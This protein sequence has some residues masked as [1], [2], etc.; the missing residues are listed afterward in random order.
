[1]EGVILMFEN[2]WYESLDGR[3]ER[4]DTQKELEQ[5]DRILL[6]KV[7]LGL[8]FFEVLD[9]GNEPVQSIWQWLT[10][11]SIPD[12]RRQ[13]FT[14]A[15]QQA[16]ANAPVLLRFGRFDWI[17]A[18]KAY[19]AFPAKWRMY[20]IPD[21]MASVMR[22][23]NGPDVVTDRVQKYDEFL[24]RS[25][26]PYRRRYMPEISAGN[27]YFRT[28]RRRPRTIVG[29]LNETLIQAAM[30]RSIPQFSEQIQP[31]PPIKLTFA[32][33]L[34]IAQVLD[35][36][37]AARKIEPL[38][39][40]ES[41]LKDTIRYRAIQTNGSIGTPNSDPLEIDGVL[42]LAGMVGSG[43]S[44]LMKL[45]AAFGAHFGGW[46]TT[47][48]VGETLAAIQLANYFNQVL[49]D[50]TTRVPVAVPLLGRTNRH[51]HLLKLYSSEGLSPSDYGPRWLDTR[52]LL[53]GTVSAND[54]QE[55]PLQA[56][57]EP[58]ER[59]YENE[60]DLYERRNQH[61]C[62]L[63]SV[64]PAQ[65]QYRDMPG[66]LI[67]ITTSGAM[68]RSRLPIQMESRNM[69]LG[70]TVY[71]ESRLVAFD[72]I[73][74][75]QQWFDNVYATELLL[76]DPS[77]GA[78]DRI[79][80]VTA[81]GI[82]K[83]YSISSY[84][85]RWITSER[86][87]REVALHV[88]ALLQKYPFL[89]NWVGQRY[90]TAHRL[91]SSLSQRLVGI[92]PKAT[93]TA[94][95]DRVQQDLMEIFGRFHDD[96]LMPPLAGPIAQIAS[97][98][99][100]PQDKLHAIAD[101]IL[102]RTGSI[103]DGRTIALCL[104]WIQDCVPDIQNV[105]TAL[106]QQRVAWEQAL[107]KKKKQFQPFIPEQPDDQEWLAFRLELAVAVSA[108]ERLVRITFD[109]WYSAPLFI[110]S[111][112]PGDQRLQRV[113][114]DLIGVIP[115]T[116]TGSLFGF[117]YIEE[118]QPDAAPGERL[119]ARHRRLTAFQ[120]NNVGRWYVLHFHDLLTK[121][122]YPGPQVLAMSGTSWLSDAASWHV[123][124]EPKAVLEPSGRSQVA[125]GSS[126]FRFLPQY[127]Q[128]GQ[129]IF[130][131][132]SPN[133]EL[134]VSELAAQLAGTPSPQA[135]PLQMD[136]RWLENQGQTKQEWEDRQRQL[137]FV[138]SYDQVQSVVKTLLEVLKGREQEIYGVVRSKDERQE[139][140]WLPARKLLGQQLSRG[141]V[142]R[143]TKVTQG[144]I[145]V[146]P[147]QAIGRGYNILNDA[148]VAAF[149][150]VYFLIRPMPQPYDM[151]ARAHWMNRRTLD[152]CEDRTKAWWQVPSYFQKGETLRKK[153][154][155]QWDSYEGSSSNPLRGFRYLPQNRKDDLAA[156]MAGIIIQAC[157][158][159]LR[160]GVPFRAFFVDAAWA[161]NSATPGSQEADTA[162]E[163]LLV[164]MISVLDRY[165][166]QDPIASLLYAPLV[167]ALKNIK[168]LNQG[169]ILVP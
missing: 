72:E 163:S 27:V 103:V 113:P 55:G 85:Q 105:L 123:S 21:L 166:Q 50:P 120:Y 4:A 56:G 13:N 124:I 37:E 57:D 90:F 16:L 89:A 161:P 43:K 54:L 133:L 101:T 38:G 86:R 42:H 41:L 69:R 77:G 151:L 137:L 138:N 6:L 48:V 94:T 125:I 3:L 76:L 51:T 157:G 132:G 31:K 140:Q 23:P 32:E 150:S 81:E 144:R 121:L 64:C 66:S 49:A 47:I 74:A 53:Q 63:F 127:D 2:I 93:P 84:T 68:A 96:P 106:Q 10:N 111:R 88:C 19:Q 52:C 17:D 142:E 141:D 71:H 95:Q 116:A 147:L 28:T 40:W 61:A 30:N 145:L 164:A 136:R 82:E 167:T 11:L 117:L 65:Q 12:P 8:R 143:F 15:Q 154:H 162:A 59:L 122:G 7:E 149:G 104:S 46:R 158:R 107:P 148:N 126:E 109:E 1:M 160:G 26:M 98:T 5:E 73:D 39:N 128:K 87:T 168:G 83:G 99:N 156:S 134:N 45:I 131:S 36:R 22:E 118:K 78:L 110:T 44:T 62:P 18:L 119:P 25:I 153:S 9:L 79:D 152:W 33:L 159:L 112:I 165:C 139:D 24:F 146:A 35:Q 115:T 130:V 14:P 67:W 92:D 129:P 60:R 70:E 100:T 97:Q 102:A 169:L 58:C 108:L 34:Q 80:R 114:Q 91:F 75:V 29:E 20:I 135:S 155:E